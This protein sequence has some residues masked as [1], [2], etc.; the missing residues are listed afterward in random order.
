MSGPLERPKKS[1]P[2]QGAQSLHRLLL[3]VRDAAS[4]PFGALLGAVISKTLVPEA[5]GLVY[6]VGVLL[7]TATF[8][9]FLLRKGQPSAFPPVPD[10]TALHRDIRTLLERTKPIAEA[11]PQNL[12]AEIVR[13]RSEVDEVSRQVANLG[14]PPWQRW[15]RR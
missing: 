15:F 10:V 4:V 12:A 2:D 5:Y 7:L 6:Y 11:D 1:V 13:L 3:L 8:G 14:K 9:A